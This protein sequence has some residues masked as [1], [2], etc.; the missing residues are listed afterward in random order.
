MPVGPMLRL[1][2]GAVV[3]TILAVLLGLAQQAGAHEEGEKPG[4]EV[5]HV[6]WPRV[7]VPYLIVVWILIASLAKIGKMIVWDP[8]LLSN[9]LF[10]PFLE[11]CPK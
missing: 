4:Y 1:F 11:V 7:Q 2:R 3:V 6:E 10:I 5:F 9:N 8:K